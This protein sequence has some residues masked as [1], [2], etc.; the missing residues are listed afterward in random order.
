ML[1][2]SKHEDGSKTEGAAHSQAA[3]SAEESFQAANP[4]TTF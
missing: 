4:K 1:S 2:L 3:P